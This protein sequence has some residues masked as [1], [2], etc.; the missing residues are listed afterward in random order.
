MPAPILA[1][2]DLVNVCR[3]AIFLQ[4]SAHPWIEYST[5]FPSEPV[6]IVCDAH[7][8]GQAITNLLQNAAESIE[9]RPRRKEGALAPGWIRVAIRQT[10]DEIVVAVEDNG[11]GLPEQGRERLAEPYVST[12]PLGTGLGLAIVKKIMED[13]GGVL[14]LHDRPEGGA[15]IKL[16]FPIAS[17][18]SAESRQRPAERVRVHGR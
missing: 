4:Q 18:E 7:Q 5:Q 9:G 12:R 8:V 2:E 3:Q 1:T 10:S 6:T 14:L 16:V 13:H 11:R 15:S 17:A